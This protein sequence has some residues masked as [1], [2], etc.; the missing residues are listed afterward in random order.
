MFI[1]LSWGFSYPG[2]HCV[3]LGL[4]ELRHRWW[5]GTDGAVVPC[6][7]KEVATVAHVE[8]EGWGERIPGPGRPRG[9]GGGEACLGAEAGVWEGERPQK[10][11]HTP[12][13]PST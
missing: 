5:G 11:R 9:P 2:P 3:T 12:T 6:A 4:W 10:C 13:V 1:C 7:F 8:E